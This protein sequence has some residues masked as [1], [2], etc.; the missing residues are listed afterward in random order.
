MMTML[1]SNFFTSQHNTLRFSGAHHHH[2]LLDLL[3][4]VAERYHQDGQA[5]DLVVDLL[6]L[7]VPKL[8]AVEEGEEKDEEVCHKFSQFLQNY[9]FRC[10]LKHTI[11]KKMRH[12]L[13]RES[14]TD[15]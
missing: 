12:I 3:Q 6:K 1:C 7:E 10:N 14:C 13:V 11:L 9:I 5:G 8:F 15:E 2:Y 4:S